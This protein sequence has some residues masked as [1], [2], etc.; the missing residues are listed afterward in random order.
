MPSTLYSHFS[1]LQ[2]AY[3]KRLLALYKG[4][5]LKNQIVNLG[6]LLLTILL[7][8][9][10]GSL[11][12]FLANGNNNMFGVG[13]GIILLFVVL[14]F[15]GYLLYDLYNS[16]QDEQEREYQLTKEPME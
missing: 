9:S 11:T 15:I 14:T 16:G 12:L 4:Y 10:M 3:Q 8:I 13:L 5:I 6:I 7:V 2:S 1:S